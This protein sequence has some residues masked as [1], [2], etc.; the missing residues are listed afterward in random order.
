MKKIKKINKLESLLK[1]S[2]FN[3][4]EAR[5][6]GVST[7]LLDYYVKKDL[8]ERISRGIYRSRESVIDVDFQY[9]DLVL[10]AGSIPDGVICLISALTLYDLT[11]E[12]SRAYWIAVPNNTKAPKRKNVNVIRMRN[13]DI[14]RTEITIGS[15]KIQIFDRERTII[16]TSRYLGKE[17]AVKALKAA[18][19]RK[20]DEKIDMRK[21][22]IYA[23][24]LRIN[25]D[26]YILAVTT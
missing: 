10:A 1:K 18:I 19:T 13:M 5:E 23:R 6:L 2:L 25:I 12:I 17:T 3:S 24:K 15:E 9:E 4:Y 16:D 11:D 7:A 8:I 14:G 20:G 21:L 26:S 22:Q